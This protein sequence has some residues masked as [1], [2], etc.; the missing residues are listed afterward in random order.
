MEDGLI[1]FFLLFGALMSLVASLGC[2][3][4]LIYIQGCMP[5]LRVELWVL[6]VLLSQ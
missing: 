6:W 1:I 3:L 5:Q 4:C 2:L